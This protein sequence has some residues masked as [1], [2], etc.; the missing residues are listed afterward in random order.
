MEGYK[1]LNIRRLSLELI[2]SIGNITW[3]KAK[4]DAI[5][6]YVQEVPIP[7]GIAVFLS[8]KHNLPFF[9]KLPQKGTRNSTKTPIGDL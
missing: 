6:P 5:F 3:E 2:F 9:S 1:S 4:S 8:F 7:D